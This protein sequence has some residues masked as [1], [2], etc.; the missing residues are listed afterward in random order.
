M[1]AAKPAKTNV[2]T[3]TAIPV[4]VKRMF[5][6]SYIYVNTRAGIRAPADLNGRRIGLQAWFTSAALWGRAILIDDYGL[7]FKSVTWVAQRQDTVGGW[8]PPD[9]LKIE[10]V[11][12]G[13]TLHDRIGQ[14]HL[15]RDA[16]SGV[17]GIATRREGSRADGLHQVS[18][19]CLQTTS[20]LGGKA[21][22][23]PSLE[24]GR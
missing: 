2:P 7:D 12:P 8:Q 4:Y 10:Y 16:P 21:L 13:K 5:R 6:H 20:P 14:S 3:M 15:C 11:P 1:K 22:R 9:W 19:R 18:R 17:R 23:R 24:R